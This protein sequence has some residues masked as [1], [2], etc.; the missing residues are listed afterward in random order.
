M[1]LLGDVIRINAQR[2]PGKKAL[3]MG[4]ESLTYYELNEQ[5]N[6][7]ANALR[8]LGIVPGDRIVILAPNCLEYVSI[9]YAVLK[10][11]GIC[12]PANFR[13]KAS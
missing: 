8:S 3:I 7:V 4:D 5:V 9:V 12:V 10:C 11:G 2:Y 13:Y 1:R 6:R